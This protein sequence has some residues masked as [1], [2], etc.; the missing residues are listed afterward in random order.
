VEAEAQQALKVH[1]AN[2]DVDATPALTVKSTT[3]DATASTK[4]S[5]D[6]GGMA[7]LKGGLVKIN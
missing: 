1:G 2:T 3:A 7:E 4:M 6:G 5:L